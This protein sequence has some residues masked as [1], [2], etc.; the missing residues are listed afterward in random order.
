V[1]LRFF[2]E[3]FGF[4]P[5][6]SFHQCPITKTIIIKIIII[7]VSKGK[8]R[9]ARNPFN[10]VIFFWNWKHGKEKYLLSLRIQ[11]VK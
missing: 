4:L 3:Q 1:A 8:Q 7:L 11:T 10:T 2:S 9:K 6:V 5:S